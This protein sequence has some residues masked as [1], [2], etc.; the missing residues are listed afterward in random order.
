MQTWGLLGTRENHMFTRAFIKHLGGILSDLSHLLS[1]VQRI[2]FI[3]RI[4]IPEY[5]LVVNH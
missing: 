4:S 2:Q 3:T 5:P 1:A